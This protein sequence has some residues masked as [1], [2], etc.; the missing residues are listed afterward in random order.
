MTDRQRGDLRDSYTEREKRQDEIRGNEGTFQLMRGKARK[1]K[2]DTARKGDR[3]G[4]KR[5]A[6]LATLA[7]GNAS[8]LW[9]VVHCPTLQRCRFQIS[10]GCMVDE[11]FSIALY[12]QRCQV[13]PMFLVGAP[14]RPDLGLG[15]SWHTHTD[16]EIVQVQVPQLARLQLAFR[17]HAL[18]LAKVIHP[19]GGC[20]TSLRLLSQPLDCVWPGLFLGTHRFK[21]KSI[22]IH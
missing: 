12:L 9:V 22:E 16:N 6:A 21:K 8:R 19:L 5:T 20:Q 2:T 13:P 14:L 4:N 1:L 18:I 7:M 10:F 11:C 3:K 17:P 15:W